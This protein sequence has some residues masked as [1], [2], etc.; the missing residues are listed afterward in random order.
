MRWRPATLLPR[1]LSRLAVRVTT[2]AVRRLH[3]FTDT[4]ILATGIRPLSK[5]RV[6]Y[7]YAPADVRG[8]YPAWPWHDYR[9]SATRVEPACPRSAREALE[10]WCREKEGLA[11]WDENPHLWLLGVE[12]AD[13]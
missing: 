1:P 5:D 11:P 10:R 9:R 4:E 12:R 3:D 7:K 6:L 8:E 13:P 2:V